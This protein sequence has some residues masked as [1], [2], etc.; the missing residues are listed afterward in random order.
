MQSLWK[1]A[2]VTAVLLPVVF[3]IDSVGLHSLAQDQAQWTTMTI[4]QA[5][6]QAGSW[7]FSSDFAFSERNAATAD[8]DSLYVAS[9]ALLGRG[10]FVFL[11]VSKD[12]G[13]TWTKY[14]IKQ[15]GDIVI[16][17]RV[18]VASYKMATSSASAGRIG[19]TPACP[20]S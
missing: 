9:T 18:K 10:W 17:A 7:W 11:H 13:V 19:S 20:I 8:D 16:G 4:G 12:G 14:S 6:A 2:T 3:V 1:W 15:A 5:G